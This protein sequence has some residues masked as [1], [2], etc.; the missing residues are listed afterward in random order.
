[1]CGIAP[2]GVR[3]LVWQFSMDAIILL[4]QGRLNPRFRRYFGAS[5]LVSADVLRPCG[6]WR[7]APRFARAALNQVSVFIALDETGEE[8]VDC[9]AGLSSGLFL[10]VVLSS[11]RLGV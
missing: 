11:A 4:R 8:V 10:G 1:M 7:W 9:L 3:R 2:A 6:P 5:C